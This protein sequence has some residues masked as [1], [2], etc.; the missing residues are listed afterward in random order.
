MVPNMTV[1]TGTVRDTSSSRQINRSRYSITVDVL[2][3]DLC[4]DGIARLE[5]R[6]FSGTSP[7]AMNIMRAHSQ[8][9]QGSIKKKFSS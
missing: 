8:S 3:F 2:L 4:I 6:P 9:I 5:T 1:F 7:S